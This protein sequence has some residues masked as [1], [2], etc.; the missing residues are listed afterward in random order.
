MTKLNRCDLERQTCVPGSI[1]IVFNSPKK[2]QGVPYSIPGRH[3]YASRFFFFSV[4][5]ELLP[6]PL[7]LVRR[8]VDVGEIPSDFLVESSS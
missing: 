7:D 3:Y 2:N 6:E 8:S 4:K 5:V 1:L